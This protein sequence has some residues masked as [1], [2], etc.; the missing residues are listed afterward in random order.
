MKQGVVQT[1]G[2]ENVT[3]TIAYLHELKGVLDADAGH[4]KGGATGGAD[5]FRSVSLRR[6]HVVLSRFDQRSKYGFHLGKLI[7]FRQANRGF[8]L[9]IAAGRNASRTRIATLL[10]AVDSMTVAS[11]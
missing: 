9:W 6:M 7:M 5:P 11:A 2:K 8:Y 1:L 4:F 10:H 3:Q